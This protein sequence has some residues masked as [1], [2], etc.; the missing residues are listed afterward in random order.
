MRKLFLLFTLALCCIGL[1][2]Q[3]YHIRLH[4][5]STVIYNRDVNVIE[6]I[7]FQGN[8]PA[9]MLINDEAGTYSFSIS[10]FDSITFYVDEVPPTQGNDYMTIC[11]NELPYT[12]QGVTFTESGTQVVTLQTPQGADSL[13]AL[14]LTVYP[15]QYSDDYMSVCESELP[16]VWQG[17]TFTEAGAKP[18]ILESSQGCDSVVTLHLSVYP[19]VTSDDYLT[20]TPSQL[21]YVWNGV[22]FT[23]EGTQT[24]TLQTIHGCDSIVNL[25]LTVGTEPVGDTVYI[26]YNGNNVTIIN[27]FASSGVAVT[28]SNADVTVNATRA[29]VPYVI[30]GTSSNGS[31]TFNS[32]NSFF[33][34]LSSLSLTSGST[35]A[36]NIASPVAVTMQ[37][38]GSSSIADNANSA[39]NGAFYAAGALTVNGNGSLQV[40]GN[41]KHGILVEGIMTVNSGSISIPSTDSDGIHGSS[42]LVWNNGTL[43]IVAPGSDGLDFSGTVTIANGNLTINTTTLSQRSIKVTGLFSMTG[44]TLHIN[45]NGNDCKG[46]KGD[47]NISINGGTVDVQ[48]SGTG[49]H[50]ISS[51]TDVIIGGNA[52]VTVVS[53]SQDGK[54]LKSDGTVHINGGTLHLTHSGN[55][56]KGISATGDVAIAGGDVT[57]TASG[58]LLTEVVE[59]Q[60]VTS[61]CTAIKSDAGVNVTGGSLHLTLPTANQSGK[62]ISANGN[63]AISGGTHTLSVSGNDSNGISSDTN[64][65][66]SGTANITI[67]SSALDGKGIKSDGTLN[68]TGGSINITHTG[69]TSKGLSCDGEINISGGT[70]VINSNGTTVVTNYD[71]SYCTAIKSDTN[72]NISGGNITITLSSANKGGKGIKCTGNMSISGNNTINIT[73]NGDGATYT[74]S[75]GTDTYS[76]TCLRSEGNMSILGGN[77]TL[78]STGSAGKGIKVGKVNGNSYTGTYT[79]G[80]SNGT[81]PTIDITTTGGEVGSSGGGGWPP[82]PGGGGSSSAHASAKAIKVNG[83]AT[84]YGGTTT[85]STSGN[86][87]E[88]L[89]SK[90]QI[91]IEGGQHYLKCKDDCI[92][93]KGKIFFNGGV[94]VCYGFGNDAVDSNAGTAG[95]ITIGNGVAF[96]YTTKGSPE[97][98]FDCDNNSYIRITGTG[99]GISAGGNQG[100]GGPGGGGSGGTISGAAQGYHFHTSSVSFQSG[101]YYTLSNASGTNLVT[102]SFEANCSSNLALITA[103]GM[104]SGGTY[105]VKYGNNAPTNPTTSFHGLYL[106]GTSSAST[107]AFSFTAN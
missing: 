45:I 82:G 10:S 4:N 3:N 37:L 28:N 43:N 50:G 78:R 46:I 64:V 74:A 71:P 105:Y 30:S 38:R 67:T 57:I 99:I 13:V 86:G 14:H 87:A 23:G 6:E 88:G 41:A 100:G 101:R 31:V 63:I 56:S 83:L 51:D 93:S 85:I 77:I 61:Y 62:G 58:S 47:A 70:I 1:E 9:R 55:A 36:I 75:S 24:V 40:T 19:T 60:S 52:D 18:I 25:H 106:G 81:G 96:A 92:N 21:P 7:H 66:V 20:V 39:I 15:T 12:W 35:A 22:T 102:F 34:A 27:P 5:S 59:G 73:T 16:Y 53:S 69:N 76:S 90:T 94:T 84:I 54:C 97:E 91:N 32:S 33:M 98:G 95:A 48:I 89:E 104:V 26:T 107:Q 80:N 65:T 72:I 29:N 49:S 17:M 103:T 2:A 44:G 11:E 68:V 79:Q 8:N 42:D